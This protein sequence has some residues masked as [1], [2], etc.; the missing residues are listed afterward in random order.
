MNT[1]S[2]VPDAWWVFQVSHHTYDLF[3]VRQSA[4]DTRPNKDVFCC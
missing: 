2:I 4:E 1:F 3:Y